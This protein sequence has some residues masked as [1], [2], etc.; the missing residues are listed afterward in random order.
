MEF[1]F[2]FRSQTVLTEFRRPCNPLPAA[3]HMPS[4]GVY[5][6][7]G[8]DHWVYGYYHTIGVVYL[9]KVCVRTLHPWTCVCTS[10]P[11]DRDLPNSSNGCGTV[12]NMVE[13]ALFG[14]FTP[15]GID[16]QYHSL[17]YRH[18]RQQEWP[19]GRKDGILCSVWNVHTHG[20]MFVPLY[21]WV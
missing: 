8:G 1:R 20:G 7:L 11:L 2:C 13:C 10:I 17:G 19:R 6:C 3:V 16:M 4:I 9:Y 21:Q 14:M 5:I 18:T 15:I 12:G